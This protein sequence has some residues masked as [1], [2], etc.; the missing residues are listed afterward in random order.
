[1][2]DVY[3]QNACRPE[4]AD[5]EKI[6]EHFNT[7]HVQ[8]AR[9]AFEHL[10]IAPDAAALDVGCGGG[11]NL[12]ALLEFC[13]DGSVTGLDYSVVSVAKSTAVNR[14][15][16]EAGRCQVLQGDVMAL[17]FAAEQFDLVTAFETVYYWPD[18]A[19]AFGQ[20]WNCLKPGG[21]FFICNESDGNGPDDEKWPEL[22]DGMAI[23]TL[24]Q[25]T[26]LLTGAGFTGLQ[27]DQ[28]A[29]KGWLC[30]TAQKPEGG[31]RA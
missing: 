21:Q 15:A 12:A 7:H 3:Y 17:P 10:Q 29:T 4:G 1:M 19:Q 31:K 11:A 13:R 30:I 28:V 20:I 8:L 6:L 9:W 27:S 14:Q 24:P 2:G 23:Y 16:V 22:I 5:G 18:L 26:A 25:L